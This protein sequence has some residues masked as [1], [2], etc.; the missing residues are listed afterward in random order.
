MELIGIAVIVLIVVGVAATVA[1]LRKDGLG[2]NPPGPLGRLLVRPGPAQQQLHLPDL[3]S[4]RT[5]V[6]TAH[7]TRPSTPGPTRD[8]ALNTVPDSPTAAAGP[9]A[10]ASR[11]RHPQRTVPSRLCAAMTLHISY[12]AELPVSERRED[13]MAAIAA[14]Q[15]TIIAGETG[16]G[17]TTQIP[18]M[19]LEL[20][21][22]ENG[23]IGHTQPRRLAARTVAERIAEEL[24]VDIGQEVGFQVRF[25]GEVSRN[26]KVKLMTD[27]ILLAEI[28][29]DK[30]LRKYNAIIIDE[31][32]ER[33]LNIDFI[34]GLPQ[35]DPAAAAGP[36]DH[37]HLGHHRS[38]S[39]SPSTS[40]ARRSPRRSSRSPAAPSRWKSATGPLSQP[41][42]G[43]GRG[44]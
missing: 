10:P 22:G 41:A 36:E 38:A 34:L 42:G 23:L 44:R 27:G 17:K 21:L 33:S 28:Q 37:H 16:S 2:H 11:R 7:R 31:A 15:V 25:T 29:R 1:A 3:L 24:G 39:V 35:A 4:P 32:H 30:L 18:K 6:H 13:L 5:P 8:R 40:A 20:G 9:L 12:P 19:C 43:A 14:N 26:T